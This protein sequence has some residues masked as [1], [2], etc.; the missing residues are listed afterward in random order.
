MTQRA[1]DLA[2][3][4]KLSYQQRRSLNL[5]ANLYVYIGNYTKAM[6]LYYDALRL[7]ENEHDEYQAIQINNN[8]GSTYVQ[9]SD[10]AKALF[11][12]R[13]A[14][15]KLN[16]YLS[17]HKDIPLKFRKINVYILNTTD[18]A[19]L[20]S[21]QLDSA[22]YYIKQ[23]IKCEDTYHINDLKAVFINDL[24]IL[25]SKKG[26]KAAA[27]KY[28]HESEKEWAAIKDLTNLDLVYFSFAKLYQKFNQPDSAIFY[29]QKSLSSAMEA[30]FF[31]D[32]AQASRLLYELYDAQH[33]TPLAYK[34]YKMAT[35]INDS[36][37]SKDKI[38]E[39]ASLDF[40]QKQH[41]DELAAAKLAYQTTI[42]NYLFVAGL[43]VLALLALIFWRNAQQRKRSNN[44]LQEQKEEIEATLEQ[45]QSTQTQLIQSEKMASLGELT[46][47]IAHEIQNPLNFVNNFSEVNAELIGEM[48]EQ[49]AKG[50]LEE[51]K[52]IAGDI[53]ENSKK[54]S[55]H[56]KRADAIVK[57]MLQH[58]QSGS[59]TKEPT[60]I[61]ALADEYLRLAYHGLRSKDKDF[62]AELV[63]DFDDKLPAINV[64]PQ[65]I[66]RVLLNLFNNAFY[67]VN[68]KTKTSGADYKPEVS[69][70]TSTVD[71]YVV[72]K[73]KDN[74]VGIP[75]AIKEKIM[76]PF[77]TT[78][79]TGEGTGL[80]LSLS[81]DIVVKGHG[82]N[83]TIDT[84]EGIFTE[85]TIS[86]P[87]SIK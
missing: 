72:I 8:I 10:N 11:F 41:E 40:E 20:F 42:R 25:E 5:L 45:L 16:L 22:A 50:D 4:N 36:I 66:G 56:G 61:N 67:A 81:Y 33:N 27:L 46:A 43:A 49:I 7:A 85:F 30:N 78:K 12:V 63:T 53:E 79:P 34:Y 18:E 52:A 15:K 2:I 29:A 48:K 73:V 3:I 64:I 32:E 80:G 21:D 83:I 86:L 47:G 70:T 75:D 38:R 65:D 71:G 82:G 74:G 60:N 54:I 44:L 87:L 59:G 23:G 51:I 19:F 24:G 9:M 68:Q 55:M 35:Q 13:Q 1:Y 17:A 58:S 26:N 39:L 6:K 84:K 28:F 57:G 62:N 77:F 14:Q 31:A 37:T 76:Q 69:V